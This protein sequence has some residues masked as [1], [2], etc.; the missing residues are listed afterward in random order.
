ML[1][2][3]H[4]F[5]SQDVQQMYF[6]IMHAKLEIPDSFDADTKDLLVKLLERDPQRRLADATQIKG[7]NYFKGIDF[8]MLLRKEITPP[9]IPPVKGKDDISMVDPAF[10]S[11]KPTLNDGP[12]A[13]LSPESQKKFEGFTF[14][15]PNEV[16]K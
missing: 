3:L 11:E 1:T 8:D 4:P 7:H 12:E 9:F 14:L 13:N 2:G 5:Y 15:P 16:K 10:T 6:R